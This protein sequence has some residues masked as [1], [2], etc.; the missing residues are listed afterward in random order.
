[1]AEETELNRQAVEIIEWSRRKLAAKLPEFL[2]AIYLL[3][4]RPS[5]AERSLWTDGETLY[6]HPETVVRD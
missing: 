6:Y 1:M 4:L 2:P 5:E 3:P